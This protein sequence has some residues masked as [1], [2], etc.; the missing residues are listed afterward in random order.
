MKN[1]VIYNILPYSNKIIFLRDTR[2]LQKQ[3]G[4]Q[5]SWQ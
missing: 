2:Y 1:F 4:G 3:G 5:S